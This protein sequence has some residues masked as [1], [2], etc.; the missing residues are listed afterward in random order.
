VEEDKP[1]QPEATK[2]DAGEADGGSTPSERE[3]IGK[4]TSSYSGAL[5][6]I[7]KDLESLR[8]LAFDM[9]ISDNGFLVRVEKRSSRPST[10]TKTALKRNLQAA[11]RRVLDKPSAPMPTESSEIRYSAEDI[12]ALERKGQAERTQSRGLADTYRLSQVLRLAGAY[13]DL[14]GARLTGL[15][16]REER[17]TVRYETQQGVKR[18][19]EHRVA[20][21]Y[22]FAV[23]MYLQRAERKS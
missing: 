13:V 21:L 1:Q 3:L 7:G 8:V 15:S 12:E 20:S 22:D 16:F 14:K 23:N 10:D 17:I 4:S 18:V 5:R 11:W 9:E 6:A 19:E 2:K